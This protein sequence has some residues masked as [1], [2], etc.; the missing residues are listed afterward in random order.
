MSAK[1]SERISIAGTAEVCTVAWSGVSRILQRLLSGR[2]VDGHR[3][4]PGARLRR[5]VVPLGGGAV[6]SE[7]LS[8][9]SIELPRID[10]QRHNGRPYRYVYGVGG[11]REGDFPNRVVDVDVE[12]CKSTVWAQPCSIRPRRRRSCSCSTRLI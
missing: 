5:Y 8:E 4:G 2:V 6:Q 3:Y 1:V 7:Q 12:G 10:Y 9:V 11:E